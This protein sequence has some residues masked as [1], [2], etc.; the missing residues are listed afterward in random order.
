MISKLINWFFSL[1]TKQNT[2]DVVIE[3]KQEKLEK[4][5]E[6]IDAQIKNIEKD[7]S[8]DDNIKYFNNKLQ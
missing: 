1:F 4:Q 6:K 7:K 5:V 3:Q 8:L 2:T